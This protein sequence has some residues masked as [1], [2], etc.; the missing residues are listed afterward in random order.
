MVVR[1]SPLRHG[2]NKPWQDDNICVVTRR[3]RP[4]RH[5]L[6]SFRNRVVPG[7]LGRAGTT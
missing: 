6:Q 4:S 5:L 3:G 7:F 2:R 1:F